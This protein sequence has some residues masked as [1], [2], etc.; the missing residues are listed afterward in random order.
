[1]KGEIVRWLQERAL[2]LPVDKR[3]EIQRKYKVP[4]EM[5]AAVEAELQDL[6][7]AE[8]EKIGR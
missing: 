6:A 1:V 2:K 5:I 8:I 3:H 7:I 4:F